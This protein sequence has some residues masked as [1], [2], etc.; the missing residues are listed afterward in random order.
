LIL[1]VMPTTFPYEEGRVRME[2]GDLLVLY[3]DGVS[4]CLD[5]DRQE[6][7]DDRLQSLFL[8]TREI[9]AE[10][11]IELTSEDLRRFARGAQQSDDITLVVLRRTR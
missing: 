10:E 8:G 2:P 4:E 7:G 6:Y 5:P 9:G 1:G 3:T 11:A